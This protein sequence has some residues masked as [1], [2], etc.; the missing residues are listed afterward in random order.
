M[1]L[2]RMEALA[3]EF[4]VFIREHALETRHVKDSS[5]G[6]R[7]CHKTLNILLKGSVSFIVRL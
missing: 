6:L 1:G 3:L 7:P 4:E 5:R 2:G